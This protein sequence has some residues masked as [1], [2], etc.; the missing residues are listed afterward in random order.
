MT[1]YKLCTPRPR[2]TET[3]LTNPDLILF[4]DG[5]AFLDPGLI[6]Q[7]KYWFL[8]HFLLTIQHKMELAALLETL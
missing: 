1:V 8:V 5:S 4:V 2:L 3:P 7:I 6:L